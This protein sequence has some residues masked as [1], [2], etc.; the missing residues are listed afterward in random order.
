MKKITTSLILTLIPTISVLAQSQAVQKLQSFA[1]NWIEPLFPVVAGLVF[2][3][4]VLVN[5]GKFFGENRDI[6]Q[7]LINI[8]IYI[9][10]L[11]L[12]AGLYAAVSTISLK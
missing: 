8:A 12:V 5:I 2:I 9:G 1:T 7:G 10:A 3:V 4:G 6:K 11:F